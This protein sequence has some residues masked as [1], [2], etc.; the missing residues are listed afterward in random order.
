VEEKELELQ[1]ERHA[2]VLR[3]LE[4]AISDINHQ[5]N[6]VALY[7]QSAEY[8][9]KACQEFYDRLAK[10]SAAARERYN[11]VIARLQEQQQS[12]STRI[13]EQKDQLR[14]L[15][16]ENRRMKESKTT[17]DR[18]IFELEGQLK[19]LNETEGL[20]AAEWQTSM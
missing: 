19:K 13:T 9:A 10:E 3:I 17:Y 20:L 11:S 4:L 15:L 8:D 16:D 12:H 1:Q 2:A 18:Q 5:I 7:Q 6:I 14:K